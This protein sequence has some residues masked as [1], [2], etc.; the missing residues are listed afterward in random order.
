MS[1]TTGPD[2]VEDVPAADETA[3]AD[4]TDPAADT[5]GAEAADAEAEQPGH[6]PVRLEAPQGKILL[7][8]VAAVVILAV[9][10]SFGLYKWQ[11]SSSDRQERQALIKR[12]TDYGNSVADFDYRDLQKSVDRSLS[13]LTGDALAKQRRDLAVSRL[14]KDWT[15]K[16]LKL[17]S[18]TQNVYL[19]ELNGNLA[20]AV[21]VFDINAESPLFGADKTGPQPV[22]VRSHLTLGLV[23]IKGVWKVSS[24][25][26]AGTE[27]D[28]SSVP[29]LGAATG[30]TTAAPTA[31]PT[32]SPT[33]K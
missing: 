9:L 31:S 33:K 24:L 5:A 14:Q 32:A 19:T 22:L 15:D 23:R 2:G 8:L 28:G 4:R 26:P 30:T 18:R 25:T 13:F 3:P 21:L 17:S 6:T 16:Q 27:S 29:G 10:A 11:S 12:V 20:G 1:T 7:T